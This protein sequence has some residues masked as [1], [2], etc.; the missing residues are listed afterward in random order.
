MRDD[1]KAKWVA[2]LRSGDYEQGRNYLQSEGKFC[3]LGVLCEV[4]VAEGLDLRPI[5]TIA[6]KV[7]DGRMIE[8]P[9]IAYVA[10][11]GDEDRFAFPPREVYEWA[12]IDFN[13]ELHAS[14]TVISSN[15]EIELAE[16]ND[17]GKHTFADI[18]DLIEAQY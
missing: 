4:A 1:I 12:D 17:S 2:A 3:C 6:T 15:Y 8:Q 11:S 13:A 5:D 9:A 18:A 10:S 16:L 7:V 14:P